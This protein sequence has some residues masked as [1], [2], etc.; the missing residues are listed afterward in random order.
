MSKEAFIFPGQGSQKTGMGKNLVEHPDPSLAM[1]ARRTFE[2]ANDTLSEKFDEICFTNPEG[3]LDQTAFTQPALLITSVAALRMLDAQERQ[4]DIVAGHSLGEYSA[5][6]AAEALS[7][8]QALKLVKARG[9]CMEEAG[10]IN[11]GRM[12]AIL[13]LPFDQVQAICDA[14]GAEIA[15]HNSEQQIVIAGKNDAVE[16]ASQL[17]TDQRGRVIGLNVSI[18]SHCGLMAPAQQQMD[19]LL[20]TVD[21]SDP[22]LPFIANISGT[23]SDTAQSVK[24]GLVD[25][26]TGTV[27]WLDTMRLMQQ[28]GVDSV[29][30]VGPGEVLSSLFKRTYPHIQRQST[31]KIF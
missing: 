13:K 21:V 4:P 18:A 19:L 7:F 5:L 9:E 10:R 3:K 26:L 6:V 15:N 24:R 1:I 28:D 2:E 16:Y 29:V 23:Y 30:E 12:A 17:A 20:R 25:Q 14:S 8:E 31:D 27:R 11:P 22:Q